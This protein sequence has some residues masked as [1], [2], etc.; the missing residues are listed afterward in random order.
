MSEHPIDIAFVQ[1]SRFR[2]KQIHKRLKDPQKHQM[3][4]LRHVLSK[5]KHTVF[6]KDHGFSKIKTWEE[7]RNA[8][9]VRTSEEYEYKYW[10][11]IFAGEGD[12]CWPGR[13][14]YF[15]VTSGTISK[16]NTHPYIPMTKEGIQS[17]RFGAAH[18]GFF[19]SNAVKKSHIGQGKLVVIGG[20]WLGKS[21]SSGGRIFKISGIIPSTYPKFIRDRIVVPTNATANMD[22]FEEKL[23]R[24]VEEAVKSNV[25]QIASIPIWLTTFLEK[26]AAYV[27]LAPG[28]TLKDIWPNLA[29]CIFSGAPIGA[30]RLTL[31]RLL[32]QD[33]AI[34]EQYGASEGIIAIK[35]E[36]NSSDLAV[37]SDIGNFYEFIPI[38][39]ITCES[40]KRLALW[41]VEKGREY[42]VVLT[43]TSGLFSYNLKDTVTFTST[44][45]HKLV[46][47]GRVGFYLNTVGEYLTQAAIDMAI[48][49]TQSRTGARVGEF[50]V[51]PGKQNG[52]SKPYHHWKM[53]FR[54]RPNDI[55]TFRN[56]LEDELSQE[57]SDYKWFRSCKAIDPLVIDEV[58][59]KLFQEWVKVYRSNDPQ[60]KIP[61]ATNNWRILDQLEHLQYANWGGVQK[62][63][64]Q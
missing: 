26:V 33:V 17:I 45:P 21:H 8:V 10:Q 12:I 4:I 44:F 49:K 50:T 20:D 18:S 2:N 16:N 24:M 22:N 59:R 9:P 30:S 56:V 54:R 31:E 11:R 62:V 51:G 55:A 23:N 37:L 35:D 25:T 6:G 52:G 14:P 48:F 38:E 13:I 63:V 39:E 32:G 61:V 47:T 46:V 41:E 43:G 15:I 34:W 36:L 27:N 19:F 60:S 53:S 5:A 7:Y 29:L 42:A 40:P 1:Y 28:R 3:R 58:P 64:A 57:G